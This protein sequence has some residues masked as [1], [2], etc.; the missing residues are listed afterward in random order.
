MKGQKS[1][2]EDNIKWCPRRWQVVRE[3][4]MWPQNSNHIPFDP[5]FVPKTVENWQNIRFSLFSTVFWQKRV[6][7]YPNIILRPDLE[8]SP[9]FESLKISFD[10]LFTF[11]FFGRPC[12]F[13]NTN[14]GG[15]AIF[16]EDVHFDEL[17]MISVKQC[18]R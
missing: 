9:H 3:F 16:Q 2:C 8:F 11:W 15:V 4:Q 5:T 12:Y 17:I 14:M 10:M 13:L 6:K 7:C 18:I 1:E